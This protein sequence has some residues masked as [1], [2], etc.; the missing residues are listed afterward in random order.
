MDGARPLIGAIE[1]G[2]Q[3][4][5]PSNQGLRATHFAGPIS[6]GSSA[7]SVPGLIKIPRVR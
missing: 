7:R 5:K 3:G 1:P 4:A 2:D 6:N